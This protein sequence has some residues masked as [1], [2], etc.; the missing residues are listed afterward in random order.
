[1]SAVHLS[2]HPPRLHHV[3]WRHAANVLEPRPSPL[4]PRAPSATLI[5]LLLTSAA[6][7]HSRL[8]P[9]L[10]E[11]TRCPDSGVCTM[12]SHWCGAKSGCKRGQ[13]LC[14]S[15]SRTCVDS[16]A[17]YAKCPGI[18]GTHLDWTLGTEARLDFLVAH[19]SLSAQIGQLH[20]TAP[21]LLELGVPEYQW[22]NDDQHGVARTP[23][24]ATV[25]PNGVGLGATFSHATLR[26]VGAVVGREARG[27]HNGFLASDPRRRQMTCNGCG[28]TLYAPNLNLV[29][30]PRWGRAQEVSRRGAA[31]E[32]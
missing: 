23:A 29:R 27:L 5:F 4:M 18:K 10:G 28:L 2:H 25:F 6:A 19:T 31:G 14:P 1:M 30:D 16:A 24:R 26:A 32:E 15:D 21:E 22:L 9:C 7:L 20:N 8:D 17:D 3:Y 12:S 11:F 13:Y